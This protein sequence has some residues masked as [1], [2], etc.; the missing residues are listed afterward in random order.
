VLCEHDP[1]L[2]IDLS[3][4]FPQMNLDVEH[5]RFATRL[6][7]INHAAGQ[8]KA[9]DLR[10]VEAGPISEYICNSVAVLDDR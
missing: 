5:R 6:A 7:G 2:N 8:G 1:A 4:H 3:G 10:I 9:M